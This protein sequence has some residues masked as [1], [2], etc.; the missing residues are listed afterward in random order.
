MMQYTDKILI[1]RPISETQDQRKK[2]ESLKLPMSMVSYC[3]SR[4][5]PEKK[6]DIK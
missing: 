5:V 6:E 3:V 4:Y 1:T 2:R